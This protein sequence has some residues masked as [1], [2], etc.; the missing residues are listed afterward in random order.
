MVDSLTR[1]FNGVIATAYKELKISL[2]Y[3]TWILTMFAA[4][5]ILSILMQSIG[6]YAGGS[7]AYSNFLAYTGTENMFVY[8]ILGA[9]LWMMA[10]VIMWDVGLLLNN[11]RWRGTLEQNAMAP[12]PFISL[13]V[14]FTIA[15]ILFTSPILIIGVASS[16]FIGGVFSLTS[17][18][19]ISLLFIIGLLP[20][21][22][23][24]LLFGALSFRSRRSYSV[25]NI[26]NT[27]LA[28]LSGSLYPIAVL[29]VWLQFVSNLIPLTHA[30]ILVRTFSLLPQ[31][32]L[33]ES[34]RLLFLVFMIVI[35]PLIGIYTFNMADR[36]AR[37]KGDFAKY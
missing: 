24:G 19:Q 9:L 16:L 6:S 13:A 17:F 3:S 23:I 1:F 34:W 14:G 35:Y 22:G 20:L 7:E 26:L 21:Y 29:P 37:R 12:V 28:I 10:A 27:T 32:F 25:V 30:T 11:E 8:L 18:F 2:R 31:F 15:D 5:Y 36:Q 33:S 4:P